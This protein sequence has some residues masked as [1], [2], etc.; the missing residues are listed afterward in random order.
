MVY[1]SNYV[2]FFGNDFR[3]AVFALFVTDHV[4][5]LKCYFAL[6]CALFFSPFDVGAYVFR[7]AL[8]NRSVDRNIEFRAF[9]TNE[10][11]P[12]TNRNNS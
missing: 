6:S 5:V 2:S 3:F 11:K 12:L 1:V 7:F 9:I 4:F 8:S 10:A